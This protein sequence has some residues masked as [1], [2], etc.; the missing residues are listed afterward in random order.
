LAQK[1]RG[2]SWY[3]QI[4]SR[5]FEPLEME[6]AVVLPEDA[7]LFRASVGHHLT[8]PSGEPKRTSFA[9]LPLS[10]APAGSAARMS[11]TDLVAFGAAHIKDGRG[12]NGSR[13]LSPESAIAMRTKTSEFKGGGITFG[14]GWMLAEGGGLQHTGGGPGIY[15]LI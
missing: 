15:S 1:V 10:F 5:I 9:F 2:E 7:V 12:L 8:P 6:H 14:L 4:E 13:I 3:D 11:A